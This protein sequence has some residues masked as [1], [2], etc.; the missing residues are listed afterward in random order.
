MNIKTIAT[1]L[2]VVIALFTIYFLLGPKAS[3]DI[4]PVINDSFDGIPVSPETFADELANSSHLYIV[5][6]L[7]AASTPD[8]RK[9]IQQCGIDFAASRGLVGKNITIYALEANECT[10]LQGIVAA[11][12][13]I[14]SIRDNMAIYIKAGNSSAFYD[15]RLIVGIGPTY[16]T[17]SCNIDFR[18]PE[19]QSNSSTGNVTDEIAQEIFEDILAQ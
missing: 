11:G 7:R 17:Q 10:T 6:D 13:C 16:P 5:Q 12:T 4:P 19:N 9:N 2:L 18:V 1:F 8:I 15:K 3:P 14:E